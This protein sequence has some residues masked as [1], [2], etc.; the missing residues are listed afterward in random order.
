MCS[1][2]IDKW[3]IK[4]DYPKNTTLSENKIKKIEEQLRVII[5]KDV[6]TIEDV[7]LSKRLY[8]DR[9]YLINRLKETTNKWYET[10]IQ[11]TRTNNN[12]MLSRYNRNKCRQTL[13]ELSKHR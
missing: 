6:V 12:F 8:M 7:K 1:N 5:S 2:F 11:P 4:T 13:Q 9:E 3:K 10:P